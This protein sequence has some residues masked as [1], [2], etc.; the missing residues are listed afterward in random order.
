MK[1]LLSPWDF[2]PARLCVVENIPN[3]PGAWEDLKEIPAGPGLQ[4]PKGT[5]AKITIAGHNFFLR[6][7]I[8]G[9]KNPFSPFLCL[10]S[11]C[12]SNIF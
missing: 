8:W 7:N 2:S 3:T 5:R 11:S 1:L 4:Q 12:T 9:W 6:R 10:F